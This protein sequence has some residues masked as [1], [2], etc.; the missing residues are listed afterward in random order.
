MSMGPGVVGSSCK[1][2]VSVSRFVFALLFWST[3]SLTAASHAADFKV[4]D[5]GAV[6]DGKADDAPAAR[7][8]LAAAIDA[9][10]GSR[11]VFEKKVYRFA[12]QEGDAVLVLDG[13]KGV[14][15]EGNGAEIIGNPW[16]AF[17]H[18]HGC[19]AITMR[20]FVLDCDPVSFTQGDI[21]E[22]SPQQGSLTLKIHTGYANPI[23]LGEQLKRKAWYRVGFTIESDRRKLKAGPIDV[24]EAITELDRSK[25]LLRVDLKAERFSHIQAGDRMVIGLQHG[26][27]GAL[28]DVRRSS[29]IRLEDYTIHSG[30]FGMNHQFADN[31]GRVRVKGAKITFRLGSTHL[32]TSIKD[33]FHVKHNRVGPILEGCL[34]EG[35]MDDAINI[36]V[37][38]YW[39]KKD[40]GEN[41][42]LIAGLTFSPRVGDRLMAYTPRPGTAE[43][44]LKVLAV[45]LQENPKGRRGAWNIITLDRPIPDLA[46]HQRG[47]LFPGGQEKMQYTGLYNLDACGRGYIVRDNIFRAQRR[48]A[49]LAR[50]PGGR[51]EGNTVDGVGGAG[52][53]LGNETGSFYEGPFPADTTVRNNTF[54]NTGWRSIQAYAKGGDVRATNMTIENN[55]IIGQVREAIWLWRVDGAVVRGNTIGLASAET[56]VTAIV[57]KDSRD[58]LIEDNAFTV[59]QAQQS[60]VTHTNSTQVREK[61]NQI[62]IENKP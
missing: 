14:T 21:V 59:A 11:V 23:Q 9:G 35:M 31:H 26:H 49:L 37:T 12:R 61:G 48:H 6:G 7:A 33:G 46:L 22:V 29:G 42:Y 53:W 17:L 25:G 62:K 32:I 15:L 2:Q 34:L 40:L 18:I 16:N 50:A 54:R 27:S 44:G 55:T 39:V 10:P 1:E 45:E 5:Y 38:P 8:A 3:L 41:R 28:I 52:V 43:Q 36:S 51:F 57:V 19:Q 60:P 30:K 24:I 47:G 58:I 13:V 20:R 56:L 4:A